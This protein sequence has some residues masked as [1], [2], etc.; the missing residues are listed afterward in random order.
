MYL[1]ECIVTFDI[2]VKYFWTGKITGAT[3]LFLLNKYVNMY[4]TIYSIAILPNH[5]LS[6]VIKRIGMF[7]HMLTNVKIAGNMHSNFMGFI[8]LTMSV[9]YPRS[10]CVKSLLVFMSL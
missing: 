7:H 8:D 9:L 6:Q 5:S 1:Y 3:V 10:L 4:Y 2:E